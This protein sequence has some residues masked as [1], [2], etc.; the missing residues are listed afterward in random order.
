MS[1]VSHIP[2]EDRIPLREKIA[3]SSG[4]SIDYIG[5][6]LMTSVLWLPV[7]NLGFGMSP[8]VLGTILMV[9]RAW[10]AVT[11]PIMGSITDNARTRWGRRRPF[12]FV[13][14]ILSAAVYP[15]IWYMPG[16][17]SSV[18]R[19]AYLTG[20]GML[21]FGCFT[22]WTMPYYGL[23]LELTPSYDERTR[24]SGWMTLFNKLSS[25]AGGWALAFVMVAGSVALNEPGA[26]DGF[27]ESVANF[28]RSIG[29]WLHTIA[30]AQEGDK[31]IVVGMRLCAWLIAATILVLGLMPALFVKER[32]YKSETVRQPPVPIWQNIRE[33]ARCRPIWT[34]ILITFLLIIGLSSVAAIGQYLNFYYVCGGDLTRA[35]VI[36][37]WKATVVMISGIAAIPLFTWMGERWDK[38]TVVALMLGVSMVGHL[39][40][41]FLM[42][43]DNPYL[44]IIPGVFEMSALSAVMMFI[45]SMKA[46]VTDYD[47]LHTQRRREGSL[48]SFFSWFV[49]AAMTASVGLSG[50]LLQLSG[51][52]A[53]LPS[54]PDGILSR[55]FTLF[56]LLPVVLWGLA[57]IAAWRFPL[58]RSRMTEIR[59]QLEAR[60]GLL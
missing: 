30:G 6:T 38:R 57:M 1:L 48:N 29:P 49:K 58:T 53:K 4:V 34:L 20:T 7:F 17:L 44:Q 28:L 3:F 50:Y 51:F 11:D 40:N 54:Q 19:I 56:L 45:P 5:T 60:R 43:P 16:E 36:A 9:L 21:F 15:L 52:D 14:A 39:T 33:S 26:F 12:I 46:D 8:A 10:D 55:M 31:P 2:T 27:S 35:S 32:Y 18:G 13:G 42:T 22:L 24:L 41:Y 37:G 25:L 47:E 59:G 23:Q